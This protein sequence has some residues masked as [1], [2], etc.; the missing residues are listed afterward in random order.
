[1]KNFLWMMLLVCVIGFLYQRGLLSMYKPQQEDI[2]KEF[3]Q[4]TFD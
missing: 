1:M 4:L 3:L 2:N